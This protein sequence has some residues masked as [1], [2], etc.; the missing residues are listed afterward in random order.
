MTT[1]SDADI[2]DRACR[3]IP[4]GVNSPVRA[5]KSVGGDPVFLDSGEGCR[6]RSRDGRTFVDYV[7]SYGPLVLGHA[8]PKILAALHEAAVK[9]TSFGAPT[10]AEVVI[11][12]KICAMVP[13]LEM[14]RLVNSGTEATMS[15]IRLARAATGRTRVVKFDGCYHGHGDSFLVK[16]G[17]GALTLGNPDSPGVPKSLAE[18][19][20]IAQFN[21]L[22]SVARVFESHGSDIAAI[23][24]EPVAGNIGCILPEP[25]FLEGLRSLCTDHG[26]LLIFDE[27]M[28]GF[29]V[30]PGGAQER[31][32]VMPDLTALGK[33]IGGGLPVGAYGGRRDL[34]EQVAPAGPVY[35]AGTLSGNPLAVAAGQAA[36]DEITRPGYFDELERTSGRV[37]QALVEAASAAGCPAVVNRCGSMLG[38]YF[39]ASPVRSLGDVMDSRRDRFTPFFHALLDGGVMPAPSAFEAWFT[40]TAHD[41]EAVATTRRVAEIA[42][43]RAAEAE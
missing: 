34:M 38:V 36:L 30:A 37:E 2:F 17:S 20:S 28:T 5:Y 8:H 35:Q 15:V 7:L 25:G 19:T 31:F 14:V 41:D 42:F 1:S 26:A 3:V 27:V 33:V 6:V 10:E 39:S 23:I 22:G 11:A 16:A 21:D 9:G 40:S 18:L 43:A 4:G 13:S 24:V 29:R 12:E 32:G